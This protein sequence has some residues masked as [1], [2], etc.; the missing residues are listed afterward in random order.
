MMVKA[1]SQVPEP[2][3]NT[4]GLA[5][6]V[7]SS[8][9]GSPG[10]VARPSGASGAGAPAPLS[11]WAAAGGCDCCAAPGCVPAIRKNG[12]M[13]KTAAIATLQ[14]PQR[15]DIRFAP[16]L[17][18]DSGATLKPRLPPAMLLALNTEVLI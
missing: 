6:N 1:W 7:T 15:T 12:A 16:C 9:K 18:P 11:G 14:R 8:P 5:G 4:I 2:L 13:A 17:G 10:L 3:T